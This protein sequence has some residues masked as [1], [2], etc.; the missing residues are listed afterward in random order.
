MVFTFFIFL[1]F[2]NFKIEIFSLLLFIIILEK[3]VIAFNFE[4]FLNRLNI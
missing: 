4:F 2:F 1:K 3:N